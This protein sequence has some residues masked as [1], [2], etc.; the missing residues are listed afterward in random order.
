MNQLIQLEKAE[1]EVVGL[2]SRC[3]SI[4]D[5]ITVI[6]REIAFQN[7]KKQVLSDNIENL[8][9][10]HLVVSAEEYRRIKEDLAR[11]TARLEIITKDKANLEN[12]LTLTIKVLAKARAALEDLK[13]NEVSNV[14]QGKFGNQN[15]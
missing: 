4:R 10:S 7:V 9:I 14:L 2:Q 11:A 6:E 15:D 13:N 8:R 1:Q 12:A 3:T 5:G